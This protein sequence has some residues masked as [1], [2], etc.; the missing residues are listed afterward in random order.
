VGAS[1]V[2]TGKQLLM[3]ISNTISMLSSFHSTLTLTILSEISLKLS[4]AI[5]KLALGLVKVN[6]KPLK[7]PLIRRKMVA[8]HGLILVVVGHTIS[9]LTKMG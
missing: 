9:S 5:V 7:N 1:L 3:L 8:V 6:C 4:S 2:S